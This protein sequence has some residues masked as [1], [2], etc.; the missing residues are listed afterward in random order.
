MLGTAYA[1]QARRTATAAYYPKAE[2][3]LRT[4]LDVRPKDNAAALDGLAGLAV[5]R[6]DFRTAK[7]WGRRR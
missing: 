2:K 6:G 3:A 7:Q 1:E 4:S 5:A